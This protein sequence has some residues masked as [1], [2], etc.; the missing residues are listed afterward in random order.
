M[1]PW[2]LLANNYWFRVN[3]E[4]IIILYESQR[5]SRFEIIICQSQNLVYQ[6]FQSHWSPKFTFNLACYFLFLLS[7][8]SFPCLISLSYRNFTKVIPY[9][10]LFFCNDC[11][12]PLSP[13]NLI[14]YRG[15]AAQLPVVWQLFV[16]PNWLLSVRKSRHSTQF[17]YD[18]NRASPNNWLAFTK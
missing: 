13:F 4:R 9:V 10:P 18:V 14:V 6:P 12:S 11:S 15:E 16:K 2:R 17:A 3:Y 8:K 7:N 1:A 5:Q